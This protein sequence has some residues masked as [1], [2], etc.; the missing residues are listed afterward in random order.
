MSGNGFD[1]V[2]RSPPAFFRCLAKVAL[3]QLLP[4]LGEKLVADAAV[5]GASASLSLAVRGDG[6]L[7][8]G[9]G[10]ADQVGQLDEKRCYV[11]ELGV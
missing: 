8:S 10:I 1:H 9:E 5:V 11:I 3:G 4:S 2:G 6:T 7:L